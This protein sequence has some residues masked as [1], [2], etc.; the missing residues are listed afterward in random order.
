MSHN[1]EEKCPTC[2][3]EKEMYYRTWCSLCERPKPKT[4][5]TLNFLKVVRHIERL[6][7]D[8]ILS[9]D[10]AQERWR[11]KPR[12]ISHK[13]ALWDLISDRIRNDISITLGFKSWYE[14]QDDP[15]EDGRIMHGEHDYTKAFEIMGLIVQEYEP[16]ID[17]DFDN[18]LWE[19]SW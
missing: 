18:V 3:G 6:Y 10:E 9:D 12:P 19:I 1:V 8:I 16:E 13:D 2:G 5:Y 7:P 17:G 14:E 15:D 11:E 4:T